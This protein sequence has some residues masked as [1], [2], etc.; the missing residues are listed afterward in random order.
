MRSG[1]VGSICVFAVHQ[2]MPIAAAFLTPEVAV[3]V[4]SGF[5]TLDPDRR[6][7]D[8]PRAAAGLAVTGSRRAG[9]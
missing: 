5:R 8:R 3:S 2:R 4:S 7:G 6:R 1:V 9:S